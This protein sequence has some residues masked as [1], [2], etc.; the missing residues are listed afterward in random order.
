MPVRIYA[1]AKDLKIDSK[2]LVDI[3]TKAGITGKGS[4]LASLEDVEVEK[5]KA[6][7][8]G[9]GKKPPAAPTPPGPVVEPV[10]APVAATTSAAN[11]ERSAMVAPPKRSVRKLVSGQKN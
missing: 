8:A 3:C 6:Y 5:L 9:G 2:E 7:L 10:R 11:R 1:L 4:A